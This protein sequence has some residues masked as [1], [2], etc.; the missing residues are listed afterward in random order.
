MTCR[1]CGFHRTC[2]LHTQARRPPQAA[3]AWQ[4][5]LT[6]NG[7]LYCFTSPQMAA[8]V[9]VL[10][11]E[12]FRVLNHL[13]WRKHD[14][15]GAG[16]GSHSK[17]CKD[18]LRSFFPQSERI[19]FCEQ[20]NADS[21]ALGESGYAAQCARVHRFVF[22][23]IRA[24]LEGERLRAG[25]RRDAINEACGL[26]SMAGR[27]YISRSQW[28]LP[29]Q[30]H[31]RVMQTLFNRTGRR[32]PPP[33]TDFHAVDCYFTRFH[34]VD[35]SAE[36]LRADYELLRAD[37]EFLRRPFTVRQDIP[38]TDVWDFATVPAGAGKHPCEKPLPL[39]RHIIE[40]SSRPGDTVLDCCAG[41]GSTLDAARQCGRTSIGIEHELHYVRLAASRLRQQCLW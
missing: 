6:P 13:V 36:F 25:I 11:G 12:V 22:E 24:Y 19:L 14:G 33:Y 37:Y 5:I 1:R 26:A 16:T 35:M 32:P 41:S 2:L 27:H 23:P 30:K 3:K 20:D 15:S 10:L 28:C 31:Y 8:H 17:S 39:L 29:T 7:S 4:R 38:Y 40:C 21:M 18:A 9:E 34:Q